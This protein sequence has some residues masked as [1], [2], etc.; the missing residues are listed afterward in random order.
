MVELVYIKKKFL[1]TAEILYF[2]PDYQHILQTYLW[3]EYD[4]LPDLPKLQKFIGFWE[5]QL[6]G[7]LHSVKVSV[8]ETVEFQATEFLETMH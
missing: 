1:T 8:G 4:T 2:M 7:P 5:D 3:Q 6:E